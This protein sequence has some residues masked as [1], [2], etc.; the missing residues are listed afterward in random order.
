MPIEDRL[1]LFGLHQKRLEEA[2][3]LFG[4]R[5]GLWRMRQMEL[6]SSVK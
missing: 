1:F 5:A 6:L 4:T 3:N 2:E